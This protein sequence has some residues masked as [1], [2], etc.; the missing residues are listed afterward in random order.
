MSRVHDFILLISVPR[1]LCIPA[2]VMHRNVPR[3]VEAHLGAAGIKRKTGNQMQVSMFGR[4]MSQGEEAGNSA[5]ADAVEYRI[6]SVRHAKTVRKCTAIPRM[7]KWKSL[8]S[9]N[10]SIH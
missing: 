7:R 8:F 4:V 9:A 1:F 10:G 5:G 3:F 2:H 6:R